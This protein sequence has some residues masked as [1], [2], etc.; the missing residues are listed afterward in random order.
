ME[1]LI[2]LVETQ[3]SVDTLSLVVLVEQIQFQVDDALTITLNHTIGRSNPKLILKID[4]L[5]VVH[6]TQK[7]L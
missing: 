1:E 3:L 7:I 4:Q 6:L 5:R 2:K